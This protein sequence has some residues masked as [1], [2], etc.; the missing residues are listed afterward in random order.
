MANDPLPKPLKLGAN[1]DAIVIRPGIGTPAVGLV[2]GLVSAVILVVTTDDQIRNMAP[3]M[4][5]VGKYALWSFVFIGTHLMGS[6][7]R[8]VEVFRDGRVVASG[9]LCWIR[10]RMEY[11]PNDMRG[12]AASTTVVRDPEGYGG[13]E[14]HR[15]VLV[16][17]S[18]AEMELLRCRSRE[19]MGD[20]R[21]AIE[22]F[23]GKRFVG[24]AARPEAHGPPSGPS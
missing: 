22:A 12:L 9:R 10:W 8:L 14:T 13:S 17:I 21:R 3:W 1:G 18:G 11:G 15:L 2:L 16:Y 6:R 23:T 4:W 19:H 7:S 20:C 5:P 24:G